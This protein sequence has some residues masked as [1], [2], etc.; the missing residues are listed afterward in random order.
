MNYA[1]LYA[2]AI[3][4]NG[5][6]SEDWEGARTWCRE[7][8]T[9]SE[10]E[11]LIAK[12][13]RFCENGELRK[14]L[15]SSFDIGAVINHPLI[16]CIL[17]EARIGRHISIWSW[18][19]DEEEAVELNVSYRYQPSTYR[20]EDTFHMIWVRFYRKERW[21]YFDKIDPRYN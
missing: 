9:T 10:G 12:A 11:Y 4:F 7:Q 2:T 5:K 20:E 17:A 14:E 13:E 21:I 15:Y 16:F 18:D 19:E 3:A 8:L 6:D 1:A